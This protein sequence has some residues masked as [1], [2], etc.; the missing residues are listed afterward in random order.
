MVG[1]LTTSGLAEPFVLTLLALL[2]S[3][4][5][6][7]DFTGKCFDPTFCRS[8]SALGLGN[9]AT[10]PEWRAK[11]SGFQLPKNS[12]RVFAIMRHPNVALRHALKSDT[13]VGQL[14]ASNA[15][16]DGGESIIRRSARLRRHSKRFWTTSNSWT[17]LAGWASL[18]EIN[19]L[20]NVSVNWICS[21][22]TRRSYKST[23]KRR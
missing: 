16:A 12:A 2:D 15:S 11:S 13:S 9:H 20:A 8:F 6:V 22:K 7:S 21:C 17:R 1:K 3:I 5:S 14:A 19:R 4:E 23:K 10:W 18:F